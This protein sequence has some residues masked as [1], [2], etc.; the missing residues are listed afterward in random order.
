MCNIYINSIVTPSTFACIPPEY[1]CYWPV[2][3][4]QSPLCSPAFSTPC[5]R[6]LDRQHPHTQSRNTQANVAS[7]VVHTANH[8]NLLLWFSYIAYDVCAHDDL[9]IRINHN[10]ILMSL[11]K[12]NRILV[13]DCKIALHLQ[14]W[15]S[16]LVVL[17]WICKSHRAI[18][19]C[20]WFEI[21]K[22]A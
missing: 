3:I 7:L 21:C 20:V 12:I 6:P 13:C 14:I 16:N 9:Q 22:S 18:V 1:K 10:H 17:H 11:H 4:Y 2:I 19:Y 5:L 15:F 8:T